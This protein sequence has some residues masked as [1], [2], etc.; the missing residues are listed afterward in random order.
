MEHDVHF[1]AQDGDLSAVLRRSGVTIHPLPASVG[2][3]T[4][5]LKNAMCVRRL[6]RNISP[7]LLHVHMPRAMLSVRLSLVRVPIVAT[8]HNDFDRASVMMRL[9]NHVTA[10]SDASRIALLGRGFSPKRTSVVYNGPIGT[11]R[12]P[13][14]SPTRELQHP[15]VT[16]V[17][18]LHERKG[19][20][21]LIVAASMLKKNGLACHLYIVGAGPD[22]GN[23]A[24]QCQALGLNDLVHFVGYCPDPRE[25]LN[26]SDVF[27]LASHDE[28]FGLVIAE[29]RSSRC[30]IVA[31]AVGG[32]PEVLEG[33]RCGLLVPPSAPGELASAITKVLTDNRLAEQLRQRAGENLGWLSTRSMAERTLHV[34]EMLVR[35]GYQ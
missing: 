3:W 8:V 22:A 14:T 31:T 10:V 35:L 29:A 16:T 21:D 12:L 27:V 13:Q 15:A 11:K 25:Y 32:I 7:D 17:C 24:R 34:Y 2:N 20:A 26:S 6:S 5:L 18:G 23:L 9:A 33:G 30:P 4:D 1:L 19:V 28:P